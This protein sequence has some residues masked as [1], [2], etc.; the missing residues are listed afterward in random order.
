[1]SI[2][3]FALYAQMPERSKGL[4]SGRNVFALVGSNP[5]LCIPF[6]IF[7]DITRCCQHLPSACRTIKSNHQCRMFDHMCAKSIDPHPP[8]LR[9]CVVA[10]WRPGNEAL[11]QIYLGLSF[12]GNGRARRRSQRSVRP[13][14]RFHDQTPF[15]QAG[16]GDGGPPTCV[17][18]R[19]GAIAC[20]AART[21]GQVH[22]WGQHLQLSH[23]EAG[24]LQLQPR[25]L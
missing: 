12:A 22:T 4:C 5:T 19:R 14:P 3:R 11:G 21:H 9:G 7:R 8:A 20:P 17:T 23:I 13:G 25:Q 24:A 10:G 18:C 16:A 2:T 15:S 1:M 6:W